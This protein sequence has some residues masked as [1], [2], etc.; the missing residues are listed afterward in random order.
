MRL[1]FHPSVQTLCLFWNTVEIW[2]TI[3]ENKTTLIWKKN[4]QSQLW[5]LWRHLYVN[6]YYCLI[7][8]EAWAFKAAQQQVSFGELCEGLCQWNNPENVGVRAAS[9][10]KNWIELGLIA[11]IVQ[12]D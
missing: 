10:L 3:Q 1:H 11:S 9:F 5:V 2:Q 7:E 4:N 6:R 8:E 12:Q